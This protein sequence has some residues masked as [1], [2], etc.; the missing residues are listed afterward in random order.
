MELVI[1]ISLI[2]IIIGIVVFFLRT[3]KPSKEFN[4]LYSKHQLA[5]SEASK[6]ENLNSNILKL[7]SKL[8]ELESS[9]DKLIVEASNFKGK[10]EQSTLE[11]EKSNTTIDD[12]NLQLKSK[13]EELQKSQ[14]SITELESNNKYL[15]EKLENQKQDIEQLQTKFKN[16]FENLA[17]KIFEDKSEKFT[18]L[19]KSNIKSILEPVNISISEFKKKIED[20]LIEETKQRTTFQEKLRELIE[21]SNKV[22][23][24]A[25]NL[26]EALKTNTKKMGNWGEIV[27]EKILEN[28]G[29]IKD[30]N[31]TIQESYRDEETKLK[32]PDVIIKL[33]DNR[34]IVIDSKV[35]LVDYERYSNSD[36]NVEISTAIQ[37]HLKSVKNHIDGLSL[38]KYDELKNSLDFVFMFIPIEPAFILA[39]K[40]DR[41]IWNYAY[42]K[43]IVMISPTNLISSLKM[44]SELWKR[45]QQ[46]KNANE[47]AKL[48]ANI[49]NKVVLFLKDFEN[50][51]NHL[52]KATESYENAFKKLNTGR[53]NILS[54]AEKMKVLGIKSDKQI[55]DKFLIDDVGDLDDTTNQIENISG[56]KK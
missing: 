38:K 31:Y 44:I 40:E 5:L 45:E 9:K 35:S 12:L 21:T 6:V 3:Y 46:N 51:N 43:N 48:G 25:N 13:T 20:N 8:N 1:I 53:G 55:E 24:D 37:D 47:I 41:D 56:D 22:S 34:N 49:Y 27:L 52:V 17:N 26:A 54:Q 11:L 39:L 7:E 16:E 15:H 30:E 10:Y 4:E 33:P 2:I 28:S 18:D 14:K 42:K 50:I 36:D 29:L 19:N 32:Y 23:Q